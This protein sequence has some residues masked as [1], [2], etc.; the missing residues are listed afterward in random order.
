MLVIEMH[1]AN[2]ADNSEA[3]LNTIRTATGGQ[4]YLIILYFLLGDSAFLCFPKNHIGF[5]KMLLFFV[6]KSKRTSQS[7]KTCATL[8]PALNA[9]KQNSSP[10]RK[11]LVSFSD[12]LSNDQLV[13]LVVQPRFPSCRVNMGMGTEKRLVGPSLIPPGEQLGIRILEKSSDIG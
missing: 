9:Q 1:W 3:G 13:I 5:Y 7:H 10:V 4:N 11:Q 8:A 2:S 6:S 12:R